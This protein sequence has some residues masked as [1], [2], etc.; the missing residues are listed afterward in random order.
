MAFRRDL[1]TTSY[2]QVSANCRARE[3]PRTEIETSPSGR[4]QTLRVGGKPPLTGR[5]ETFEILMGWGAS[6]GET[7]FR[8]VRHFRYQAALCLRF[9][10][11]SLSANALRYL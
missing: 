8:Q 2:W 9:K 6:A 3:S 7:T 5:R 4:Q 11:V 1:G 10:S